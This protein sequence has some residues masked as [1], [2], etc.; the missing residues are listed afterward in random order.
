MGN[1]FTDATAI[2]PKTG[3]VVATFSPYN[4]A[5]LDAAIT[6]AGQVATLVKAKVDVVLNPLQYFIETRPTYFIRLANGGLLNAGRLFRALNELG[7]SSKNS[8]VTEVT[9]LAKAKSPNGDTSKLV[10]VATAG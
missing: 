4:N 9:Q 6:A 1:Y 5:T 10:A 8:Q 3:E 2:D 7:D